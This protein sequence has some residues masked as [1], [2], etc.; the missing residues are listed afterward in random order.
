MCFDGIGPYGA[1]EV[2]NADYADFWLLYPYQLNT[3][4]PSPRK[5]ATYTS[6]YHSYLVL[7]PY[8][9][10]ILAEGF[11]KAESVGS[12]RVK[13]FDWSAVRE[14]GKGTYRTGLYLTSPACYGCGGKSSAYQGS[15]SVRYYPSMQLLKSYSFTIPRSSDYL[16]GGYIDVAFFDF[17][18]PVSLA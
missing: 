18:Q 17:V 4:L 9:A 13:Y 15:I 16:T 1:R 5:L 6:P 11:N 10:D 14:L 8:G 12:E 2:P 3:S 7:Y